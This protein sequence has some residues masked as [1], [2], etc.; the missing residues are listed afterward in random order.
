M[1]T[2]TNAMAGESR[3]YRWGNFHGGAL[4]FLVPFGVVMTAFAGDGAEAIVLGV[5]WL[6]Y[7]LPMGLGILKKRRYALKMVYGCLAISFLPLVVLPSSY[8]EPVAVG[9]AVGQ[10]IGNLIIW[11]PSAAYYYKRRLE[12]N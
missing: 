11:V 7:F 4:I 9:K 2:A 1:E 8:S 10:A 3:P 6:F 12:F 5:F